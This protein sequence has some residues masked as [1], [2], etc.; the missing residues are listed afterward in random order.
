MIAI[1][2]TSRRFRATS[3]LARRRGPPEQP[4]APEAGL[5]GP[6]G[7]HDLGDVARGNVARGD[8]DAARGVVAR[9]VVA[10]GD[11]TLADAGGVAK[12]EGSASGTNT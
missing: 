8:G 3:A 1:L 9:G 4:S 7:C 5:P 12:K 6:P 11:A 10:R 2:A